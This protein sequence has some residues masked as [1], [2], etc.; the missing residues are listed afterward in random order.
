MD[1]IQLGVGLFAVFG[2]V[3]LAVLG[4]LSKGEKSGRQ[5]AE[6]ESLRAGAKES[7]DFADRVASGHSGAGRVREY[8][9]DPNDRANRR[10]SGN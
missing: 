1:I 5:E 8:A 9:N 10:K 4:L 6:N 3:I 7:S 2:A